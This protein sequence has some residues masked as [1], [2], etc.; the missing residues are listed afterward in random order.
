MLAL[1]IYYFFDAAKEDDWEPLLIILDEVNSTLAG[2]LRL[3][4]K[5]QKIW[6]DFVDVWNETIGP[7]VEVAGEIADDLTGGV[8]QRV[9]RRRAASC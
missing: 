4:I 2:I 5:L 6:D 8:L 9:R 3:L 1:A 7:F